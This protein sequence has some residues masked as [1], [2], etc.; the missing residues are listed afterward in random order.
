MSKAGVIGGSGLYGMPG[1]DIS[2]V[3]ELQTPYGK[4]SAAYRIG[5][6]GEVETVFLPRHGDPHSIPPH[7]INY[8]ANL[9]GFR[10]L[11]VEHIYSVNASGGISPQSGPGTIVV[12]DQVMDQ[13]QGAREGTFFDGPEVVHIDFTDPYCPEIR[14]SLVDAAVDE[15]IEVLS[16]GTYL[17]VNGPRLESRAEIKYFSSMGVDVIGMTGMPEA[18]LA[19]ELEMCFSSLAVV[20]NWAAGIS[21]DKLSAVEVVEVMK[22]AN[23]RINRL[24]SA[25]ILKVPRRRG[26]E[27]GGALGNARV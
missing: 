9:W 22:G 21:G 5:K 15:G 20:A 6:V 1:L 4:P 17:C 19:R 23:D 7:R 26:C 27:C 11:G 13:T 24:L 2:E 10:E 3:R 8:R 12:C 14:R 18:A 25:A 16:E